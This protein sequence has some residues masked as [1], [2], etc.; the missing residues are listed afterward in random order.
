MI[1][2]KVLS[3][4]Y[5][6]KKLKEVIG[7]DFTVRTL[8]NAFAKEKL[9]HAFLF[10]GI[11]GVGKTTIARIIAMG[12]NCETE[13]KPTANP[14]GICSNC[15]A[16][17]QDRYEDVL[18]I[19]AAS[20]T[21]V[22]DVR[23]IISSLKYRPS[24]GSYKVFI[25]DEVHMLSNSA[26]NALLKTIEEPPSF[27]KFIFCTTEMQKIPIT[28]VSRC[29]KYNLNR[30]TLTALCNYL[31][32]I[33]ELEKL[34][35]SK[36][37]ISVIARNSEG[38][39]RDSLTILDQCILSFNNEN[40]D[41]ESVNQTMGLT[42][43]SFLLDLYINIVNGDI[44]N[45]NKVLHNI[46]KNGAA[47]KQI[48]DDLLNV[49]YSLISSLAANTNI[50]IYEK[51]KF[52]TIIDKCDIPFLNQVWHMLLRGK[53][54]VNKVSHQMEALEILIIRIAYSSQLPSLETVVKKIKE[55]NNDELN[56]DVKD[57]NIGN[58]IK[59]ILDAFPEG[60]VL[61]N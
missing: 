33:V 40:I 5:R 57:N 21:G 15:K 13:N 61:K 48:I 3:R 55:D 18:E 36:E 11:R 8:T 59:K 37:A 2:Y 9:A 45:A 58:D 30:V 51:D 56:L 49:T 16:I 35:I 7:Q 19:D 42:S 27:V 38:S 46:Y 60:K 32:E 22:D 43:Q 20:N 53:D 26:F 17:L 25:I 47:P 23:E 41:V 12:L 31:E 28:I 39:I 44:I 10:T 34:D 4:K 24:K 1:E 50:E 52:Q 14:C 29:Q 54:E 6:P